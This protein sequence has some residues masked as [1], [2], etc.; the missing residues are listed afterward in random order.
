MRASVH[1]MA[2]KPI[3][4]SS[5]LAY[6]LAVYMHSCHRMDPFWLVK[7]KAAEHRPELDSALPTAVLYLD[8]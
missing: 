2:R 6:L 5:S 3:S 8:L 4:L 7:L 1:V